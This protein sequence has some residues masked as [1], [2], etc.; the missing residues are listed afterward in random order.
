MLKLYKKSGFLPSLHLLTISAQL[1][2]RVL[3]ARSLTGLTET[4][5]RAR[6]PNV[7]KTLRERG[8]SITSFN[9]K[10]QIEV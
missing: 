7:G 1:T 9:R 6:V 3:A 8:E 5:L 10:D 4:S 2:A